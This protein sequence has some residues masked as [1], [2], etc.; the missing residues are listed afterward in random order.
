MLARKYTAVPSKFNGSKRL[1]A[2]K[3]TSRRLGDLSCPPGIR[4]M[5]LAVNAQEFGDENTFD[6]HAGVIGVFDGDVAEAGV[7]DFGA[8]EGDV[9]ED[10]VAEVDVEVFCATEIDLVELGAGEIGVA[11][12]V[13]ARVERGA[14]K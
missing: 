1:T 2:P 11:G 5:S 12:F 9:L 14:H 6:A 7:A 3:K 8:G 10:G 13:S 4:R